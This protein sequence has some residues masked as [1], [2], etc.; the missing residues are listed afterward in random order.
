MWHDGAP[1]PAPWRPSR[2]RGSTPPHPPPA[3]MMPAV[4]GQSICAAPNRCRDVSRHTHAE[5]ED[6]RTRY[7]ATPRELSSRVHV[8]VCMGVCAGGELAAREGAALP[9]PA[10]RPPHR[11]TCARQLSGVMS[12][13]KTRV[14]VL[15]EARAGTHQSASVCAGWLRQQRWQHGG[16]MA[17]IAAARAQEVA[18][19]L[20]RHL[21]V[22]RART[23]RPTAR[24]R[25]IRAV[26]ARG[27]GRQAGEAQRLR[28]ASRR[29]AC[30]WVGGWLMPAKDARLLYGPMR[31]EHTSSSRRERRERRGRVASPAVSGAATVGVAHRVH[32]KRPSSATPNLVSICNYIRCSCSSLGSLV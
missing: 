1:R 10:S 22:Q 17:R 28:H 5:A 11:G 21:D 12:A 25:L 14:E 20:R 8:C 18:L 7:R 32:R 30:W 15:V 29:C 24:A 2:R 6:S 26:G 4:G 31:P 16:A 9:A 3:Q 27:G 19:S 23:A 13:A